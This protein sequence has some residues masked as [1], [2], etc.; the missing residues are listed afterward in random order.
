MGKL[1]YCVLKNYK[2]LFKKKHSGNTHLLIT[3][4]SN[5]E[6]FY[7]GIVGKLTNNEDIYSSQLITKVSDSLLDDV[8]S[9]EE[10]HFG[11]RFVIL[12]DLK[13]S[14][15]NIG[16]EDYIIKL[17]NKGKYIKSNLI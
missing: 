17:V 9:G 1:Y 8:I 12:E 2:G 11:D 3:P 6:Y 13:C 10:E 7:L 5:D 14:V 15:K 16:E 4:I